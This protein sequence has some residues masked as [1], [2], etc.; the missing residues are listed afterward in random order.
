MRVAI[1]GAGRVGCAVGRALQQAGADVSFI[2]RHQPPAD[3]VPWFR[4]EKWNF[5]ADLV[6]IATPDREIRAVAGEIASRVPETAVVGHFSGALGSDCLS[7]GFAGR[8]SAHP[9][10]A[11]P[12]PQQGRVLPK[13]VIFTIEGDAHGLEMARRTLDLLHARPFQINRANKPLYH[14]ACVIAANFTSLNALIASWILRAI[15]HPW[16]DEIV[17]ALLSSAA[18]LK[19]FDEATITGP[20]TRGDTNVIREHIRALE[21]K[22]PL[23]IDHYKSSVT[24]LARLLVN[25]GILEEKQW[26]KI[27]QAL[28]NEKERD[29]SPN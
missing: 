6:L 9:V 23:F 25:A 21:P 15:G 17:R 3:C 12:L 22:F 19:P 28:K 27:R 18:D 11:F 24:T 10:Y 2:V 8:F 20:V 26:K 1:A 7:N 4:I 16:P 13:N 5:D 14:A 29:S